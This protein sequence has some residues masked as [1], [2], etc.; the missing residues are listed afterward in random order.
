MAA[1]PGPYVILISLSLTTTTKLFFLTDTSITGEPG[2]FHNLTRKFNFV[3][4]VVLSATITK[5][6]M[7]LI[8]T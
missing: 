7:C 3:S 4:N 1:P 6:N 2:P 5:R 8:V